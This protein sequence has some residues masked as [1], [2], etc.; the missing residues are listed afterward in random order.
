M[1]V[2]TALGAVAGLFD[3]PVGGAL[4][5]ASMGGLFGLV[6]VLKVF[7]PHSRDEH[8]AWRVGVLVA[9]GLMAA[10]GAVAGWLAPD[11]IIPPHARDW[12]PVVTGT[13][14]FLA[15]FVVCEWYLTQ[16]DARRADA[17]RDQPIW[18]DDEP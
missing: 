2:G 7:K 11:G 13:A 4:I 10:A 8:Q 18:T 9:G 5:G 14:G 17:A 12:A 1:G 15:G 6:C 16:L 3:G